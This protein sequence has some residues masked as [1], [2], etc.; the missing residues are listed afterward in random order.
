MLEVAD[1]S[2]AWKATHEMVKAL[3]E[4]LLKWLPSFWRIGKG[5][6]EGKYKKV[7][8]SC[9]G[10]LLWRPHLTTNL[11]VLG[12]RFYGLLHSEPL[13]PYLLQ[14][15]SNTSPLDGPRRRWS[16]HPPPLVL[17][18]PVVAFSI[19]VRIID[20]W[21]TSGLCSSRLELAQQRRLVESHLDGDRRSRQRAEPGRH[22][23]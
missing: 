9:D 22:W 17:L 4:L 8:F 15:K 12:A 3:S 11:P 6:L 21:Q 14:A 16:L 20:I 13:H 19:A 2:Q 5:F 7:S 1:G 10:N 23:E 18:H